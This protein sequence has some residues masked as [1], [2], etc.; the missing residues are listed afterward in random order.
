MNTDLQIYQKLPHMNTPPIDL[1]TEI[2]SADGTS[3][4]FFQ[5]HEER[6]KKTLRLLVTPRLLTQP[7]LVLASERGVSTVPCR[8]IDMILARTSVQVPLRFPLKSPVGP[9]DISEFSDGPAG[10][11]PASLEGHVGPTAFHVEIHTLGGWV[12]SL[13]LV[14]MTPGTVHDRRQ[15]LAH[16][17]D[18]PVIPFR[19]EAGGIGL[20]NPTNI[21]R[22][23]ACPPPPALPETALPMDLIR[24]TPR[25]TTKS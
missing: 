12:T 17:L 13:K 19:L 20:I 1:T 16:L 22:V 25:L 8:A 24:W 23:S 21:T 11:V 15:A 10:D 9:L 6:I 3:A 2:R 14:A 7:Q 5:S 18:L 4:E